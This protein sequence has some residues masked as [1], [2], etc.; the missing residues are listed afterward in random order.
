MRAPT[1]I[2]NRTIIASPS[3]FAVP[4]LPPVVRL[5]NSTV[6]MRYLW[7]RHNATPILKVFRKEKGRLPE[8]DAHK[9]SPSSCD[10]EMA[11]C[12]REYERRV[13]AAQQRLAGG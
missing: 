11:K 13:K 5:T 4:L 10:A 8:A 6:P 1:R 3:I 9:K 12:A 2:R 7:P